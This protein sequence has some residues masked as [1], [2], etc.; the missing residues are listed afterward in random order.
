MQYPDYLPNNEPA[1]LGYLSV[2]P[3]SDKYPSLSPYVYCANNPVKCIDPD[4]RY[5]KVIESGENTYKVVGGKLNHD[6]N[7]YVYSKDKNGD[8]NKRGRCIGESVCITSFYNTDMKKWGVEG[9]IDLNNTKGMAF[10]S[11]FFKHRPSL[12]N[13]KKNACAGG[14]YDF[15]SQCSNMYDGMP[16]GE[17]RNGHI[18]IGSGRDIG[19]IPAGYLLGRYGLTWGCTRAIF[20]FH[21]THE[22]LQAYNHH[23]LKNKRFWQQEWCRE[24]K[25]STNAQRYGFEKGHSEFIQNVLIFSTYVQNVIMQ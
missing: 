25:S 3:L 17:Q 12:I 5:T 22:E 6:K 24:T 23:H 20:D 2:D 15:K 4:G 11:S 10:L 14:S 7:V 18:V 9:I 19:N 1:L 13:Y 21:Q 16:T 8:Y